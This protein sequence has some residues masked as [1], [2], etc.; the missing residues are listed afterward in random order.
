MEEADG[1]T[2][3][4]DLDGDLQEEDSHTSSTQRQLQHKVILDSDEEGIADLF[5]EDKGS[6]KSCQYRLVFPF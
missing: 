1:L 5:A 6:G 4:S 2:S 3:D